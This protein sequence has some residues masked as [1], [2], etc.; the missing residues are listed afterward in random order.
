MIYLLSIIIAGVALLGVVMSSQAQTTK[1]GRGTSKLDKGLVAN[2]W[3]NLEASAGTGANGLRNAL[4][5]ADKLFDY[6]MQG[7]GYPG[8]TFAERLKIAQKQLANKEAVWQAHKLRNAMAHDINFDLVNS[9]VRDALAGFK[10]GLK[11]L[12][13]L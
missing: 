7:L 3:N 12:G 5:E 4:F 2:R 8:D 9:Q 11:D 6:C 10:H 1:K 13:A